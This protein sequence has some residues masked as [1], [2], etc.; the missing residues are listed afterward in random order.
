MSL[1]KDSYTLV[2]KGAQYSANLETVSEFPHFLHDLALGA[3]RKSK[4]PNFIYLDLHAHFREAES[5]RNI[6][7]EASKRVDVLAITGRTPEDNTGHMNFG[8]VEEKLD[9]E[10]VP[11]DNIG[12]KVIKVNVN[13]KP[14]YLVQ[15]YEYYVKENQG[16]I[17]VGNDKNY[18]GDKLSL[19]HTIRESED[20]GAFWFLD[21]PFSIGVP[22]ISFRY[23]TDEELKMKEKWFDKDNPVIETGNHQNTLWM[24]PSNVLA[25]R[26]AKKH[27]LAEITN[28]DT[29][30][31]VKEVGLSRTAFPRELFNDS[32]EEEIFK[33]FKKA[34]SDE[35]KRKIKIES[36]YA[37]IW[38]FGP[39]MVLP[40]LFPQLAKKLELR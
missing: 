39:Y 38:S 8:H 7:D 16:I 25:R 1:V 29:H 5:I 20:K 21:H 40:A 10:Q 4:D 36:G 37:S 17:M 22:H 32:S 33:S 15:A 24:F 31:R 11:H 23:P 6:V 9:R 30:F 26:I 13:G 2:V 35:H 28:S 27:G 18:S 12:K 34:F 19:D 3:K 14:L